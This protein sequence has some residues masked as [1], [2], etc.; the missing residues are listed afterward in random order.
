MK[1]FSFYSILTCFKTKI[2]FKYSKNKFDS[3]KTKQK[4]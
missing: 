2:L 4:I 1:F 3:Y